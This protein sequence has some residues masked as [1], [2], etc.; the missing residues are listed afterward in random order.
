MS[1]ANAFVPGPRVTNEG[2]DHNWARA[3]GADAAR[4]GGADSARRWRDPVRQDHH[5]RSVIGHLG[6]NAFDGATLNIRASDG[7]PG[8]SSSGY[9]AAVAAGLCDTALG[10]DTGG[11]MRLSASFYS[12]HGIR[13]TH[14]RLDLTG[15]LPQAPSSDTTGWFARDTATFASVSTV[16]LGEP[17]HLRCPPA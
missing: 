12:R 10:T 13:P 8:G 5:R 6:N 15:M 14:G 7:V 9:G 3:S 1:D 4:L 16:L 11:S 17:I 2:A